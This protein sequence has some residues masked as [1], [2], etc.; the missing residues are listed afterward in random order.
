MIVMIMPTIPI[1][2]KFSASRF[3]LIR[4]FTLEW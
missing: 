4:L 3:C 1:E 2:A